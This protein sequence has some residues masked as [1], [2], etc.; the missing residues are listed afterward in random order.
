MKRL[1]KVLFPT[2][3][4]DCA[5]QALSHA[6]YFAETYEAE[7]HLLHAIVLHGYDPY[8]PEQDLPG[9]E[10][11]LYAQQHQDAALRLDESIRTHA[12]GNMEIVQVEKRGVSV[13]PVILDYANEHGIDLI[14]MG[15]HGRRGLGQLFLGS[16][17]EEIV[18]RSACPVLTVREKEEPKSM[19]EMDEILV[20]MDFSAHSRRAL[21]YAQ[22]IAGSCDAR[23]QLL[24]VVEQMIHPA[25]YAM[26]KTSILDLDP[27][28]A[29]RSHQEM[30][31]WLEES[32]GPDVPAETF[33]LDGRASRDIVGFAVDNGS[34]LIVIATHGLTGLDRFLIGS[35]TQKVVRRADCPVF[36][37]KPFG[38]SLVD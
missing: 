27:D 38:K 37:V 13:A 6:V 19:A 17:A 30:R 7:L 9:L 33:V 15:T 8:N 31:R 23:L 32:K 35:T 16:V 25:F 29:G 12:T 18:R 2:D 22:R 26:G 5:D 34:D 4:S 10:E 20:P 21:E 14:V 1:S 28:I 11:R 36:T 24:H 3:F